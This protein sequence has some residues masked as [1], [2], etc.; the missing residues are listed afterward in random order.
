MEAFLSFILGVIIFLYLF[1]LISKWLFRYWINKKMR[2]M[3]GSQGGGFSFKGWG[4]QQQQ[5]QQQQRYQERPRPDGEVKI[6][7]PATESRRVNSNVGEYVDFEEV[8]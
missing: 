3:G 1:G 2:Q 7:K 8:K 6:S 5:Q 4:N